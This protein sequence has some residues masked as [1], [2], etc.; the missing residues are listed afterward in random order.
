MDDRLRILLFKFEDAVALDPTRPDLRI[1]WVTPG[2]GVDPG[3]THEQA[4]LRE[5]WEETG[6]QLAEVGPWIWSRERTFHFPDESVL[7]REQYCLAR[8][9]SAEICLTNMLPYERNVYRDH[10]WWSIAEMEQ[11]A[12]VFLP[13]GLPRLLRPLLAG[14]IPTTPIILDP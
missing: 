4:A 3:E 9:S 6:I 5:L 14:V 11:S 12:E 10:R 8:V 13:P 1:Y 2:G 7:V